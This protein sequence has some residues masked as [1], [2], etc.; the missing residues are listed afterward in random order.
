MKLNDYINNTISRLITLRKRNF[1]SDSISRKCL[2]ENM[3]IDFLVKTYTKNIR[4]F[5]YR[6]ITSAL[7]KT[8][9]I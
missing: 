2:L 4:D 8:L 9:V 7:I 3:V 5:H 1:S 6:Q